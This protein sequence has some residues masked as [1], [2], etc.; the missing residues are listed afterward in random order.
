MIILNMFFA[1]FCA[2]MAGALKTTIDVD[3]M[4]NYPIVWYRYAMVV[5]N[6]LASV[7]NMI[8]VVGMVK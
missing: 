8:V 4:S 1:I 2:Y 5:F 7:L 6:L 3:R